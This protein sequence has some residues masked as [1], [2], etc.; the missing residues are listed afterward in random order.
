MQEPR[1][2]LSKLYKIF[3]LTPIYS[4]KKNIF[5]EIAVKRNSQY[6]AFTFIVLLKTMYI[7]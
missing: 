7:N 1:I 2:F 5:A 4:Y 3:F 6:N